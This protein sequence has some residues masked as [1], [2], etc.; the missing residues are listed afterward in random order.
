MFGKIKL[1]AALVVALGWF[2]V[3]SAPAR[4]YDQEDELFFVAQKAFE[5][6]FYDVALRY[7]D[8]FLKEYPQSNK[9]V[10]V[11]LL[12]GQCYFFDNQY[13]KAFE[14]FEGLLKA[15]YADKL[16]DAVFFWLGEVYLKGK[17][18]APA[19]NYYRRLINEYPSSDYLPQAYYSL[20]WVYFE[21]GTFEKA[22]AAFNEIIKRTPAS[23]LAEDAHLKIGEALF[24]LKR[25]R[26]ASDKFN[27]YIK[28]FP[29]SARLDQAYFYLGEINYY[30]DNF[31]AAAK[32]YS[33]VIELSKEERLAN[34]A[35]LSCGW[36]YL[37]LGKHKEALLI[38]EQAEATAKAKQL[39][40]DEI[41]LAKAGLFGATEDYQKALTVYEEMI[42]KWPN[43][44]WFL[45][46]KL[47]RAN[48][49]HEL[50][51]YDGAVSAYEEIIAKFSYKQASAEQ[52]E[53]AYFGL[54]WSFLK[55]GKFKEAIE[56]FQK[57]ME[58]SQDRAIRLSALCQIADVYQDMG[59]LPQAV[60]MYD[61][62]LREYPDSLYNDY[63]Q[64]RQG[65]ALLKMDR[66]D[67]AS[68][69]FQSLGKNFPKSRFVIDA[70][71][72]LA[73]AYFKK[74]DL[75]GSREQ[76]EKLLARLPRDSEY[77]PEALYYLGLNLSELKE[78]KKAIE[79]FERLKKDYPQ[80]KEWQQSAD[81]DIATTLFKW[82]KEP[83]AVKKFK[84]IIYKFPG[85]AVALDS[86]LWLA[87]YYL[88]LGRTDLARQYLN[89]CLK[90]FASSNRLDE[91][92]YF[93]GLSYK[94]D[95][96]YPAATAEFKKILEN[97][98]SETAVLASLG[99]ADIFA[100]TE[101][102]DEAEVFY[103]DVISKY[104][105]AARDAYVKIAQMYH[106]HGLSAKAVD[107]LQKALTAL[108]QKSQFSDPEIQFNLAEVSEANHDY[109]KAI[110]N[111]L[112]ITYLYPTEV[113]WV[114]K[115]YLRVARIYEDRENW[116]EAKRIYEKIARENAAE[117]KF[118]EE[119]LEWIR[120]NV[121]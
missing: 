17:D 102:L 72:Y 101:K 20:G 46:A 40:A 36:A 12:T 105:L 34:L 6:G 50:G 25:Y 110:E 89:E 52:M 79:S 42:A 96:N 112:K 97:E 3:F 26:E 94:E 91:A 4:S 84:L 66:T 107:A 120:N 13:L 114:V 82:G 19:E 75:E 83:E 80:D 61:K 53:K 103:Q 39:D 55:L 45:D 99:L 71:Y 119:R 59:N 57:V 24:G 29:L 11:E 54:G 95:K 113:S 65:V 51:E 78:Y 14:Q 35:R 1:I 64:Y 2:T 58:A 30:Q 121:K 70:Q 90:E 68:L 98:K 21:Q 73:M 111:Y 23:V 18:Y 108:P 117:A 15:P 85:S 81:F 31:E 41:L 87:E 10:E 28:K 74:G 9:R 32:N 60:D 109:H 92:R 33:L 86:Y 62:I 44:R 116:P 76:F 16:R 43:S 88:K 115:S 63:V 56:Y 7:L 104:P 48:C 38:L 37:R 27:A 49:L 118:A 47:G 69:I 106:R 8:Q 5:D 67:A 100:A 22:I 93:L 77:R